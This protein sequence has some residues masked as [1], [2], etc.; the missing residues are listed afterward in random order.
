[1]SRRAVIVVACA[2]VMSLIL[3][4]ATGA[5]PRRRAAGAVGAASTS[6]VGRIAGM[7]RYG[8]SVAVAKSV[9]AT[10]S[11]VVIAT[12]RD[13]RDASLAMPLAG[14]MSAPV[15]LTEGTVVG[16]FLV[17]GITDLGATAATI[18]GNEASVTPG[19]AAQLASLVGTAPARCSGLD[20]FG[21]AEAV[22]SA[23][24]SIDGPAFSHEAFLVTVD[25]PDYVRTL[26]AVAPYAY[27]QHIP[28]LLASYD[29]VRTSTLAKMKQLGIGRVYVLGSYYDVTGDEIRD[30]SDNGFAVTHVSNRGPFGPALSVAEFAVSKGWADWHYVGITGATDWAFAL[31]AGVKVGREGGVTLSTPRTWL[32]RPTQQALHDHAADVS[33]MDIFGPSTVVSP[34][35]ESQLELWQAPPE[36][37]AISGRVVTDANPSAP[38]AGINVAVYQAYSPSMG[39]DFPLYL[40]AETTTGPD[41]RYEVRGLYGGICW[42]V[43]WDSHGVYAAQS[44]PLSPGT[45]THSPAIPAIEGTT[46]PG[47]DARMQTMA[48]WRAQRVQ[49]IQGGDR[50]Q[51][52]LLTSQQAFAHADTVVVATGASFADALSASALCGMY[53]A[54][55]LLTPRN[56]LPTWFFGELN[57]LG[58]RNILIVGGEASVNAFVEKQLKGGGRTVTRIKGSDR[59]DT[60]VKVYQHMLGTGLPMSDLPFVARGDAFADAL[61]AAPFAYAQCRPILLVKPGSAP[62]STEAFFRTHLIDHIIV[63]GGAGSVSEETLLD[64]IDSGY[65]EA[66]YYYRVDGRDRYATAANLAEFWGWGYDYFGLA[67]GEKFADALSGGPLCGSRQGAM[68]LT[69]KASLS[70]PAADVLKRNAP[71]L[72]QLRVLGSRDS[73]SDVALGGASSDVSLASAMSALSASAAERAEA[74]RTDRTPRLPAPAVLRRR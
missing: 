7:D 53:Q 37:A 33:A 46:T 61:S 69:R 17:H 1:M 13:P 48:Q 70:R 63:L 5:A 19:V 6:T 52:C 11:A 14:A 9:F 22:A 23:V 57:R 54:P 65:A 74:P 21:T 30:L 35:V 73:V 67:T 60:A 38:L 12:G 27:R 66:L 8:T 59:Y 56:K 18:V 28:I 43:F 25:S 40:A 2:L 39:S 62:S 51:T 44:Y 34:G 68:L 45:P 41:G 55:L 4:P 16:D 3:I 58:A 31:A 64:L 26:L 50:Y 32:P 24:A 49:R 10:S 29:G 20:E 36:G 47:I 71:W 72:Y 42:V 15:L